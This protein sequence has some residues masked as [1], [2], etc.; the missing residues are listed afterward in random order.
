MDV[1]TKENPVYT[2]HP[3]ASFRGNPLIEALNPIPLD[4]DEA[5]KRMMQQPEFNASEVEMPAVFR[6]SFPLSYH[7]TVSI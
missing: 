7:H 1:I 3:I 5:V 2:P 4:E 6:A